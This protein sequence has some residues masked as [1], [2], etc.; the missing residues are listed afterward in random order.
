MKLADLSEAEAAAFLGVAHSTLAHARSDQAALPEEQRDPN[1]IGSIPIISGPPVKYRLYELVKFKLAQEPFSGVIR[2]RSEEAKKKT[3]AT[4]KTNV[5]EHVKRSQN[6]EEKHKDLRAAFANLTHRGFSAFMQ[7]ATGADTWP[8]SIQPDGRPLDLYSA[9]LD[10]KLSGDAERLNLHE[11]A[12]RLVLA[13]SLAHSDSEVDAL[14][15]VALQ[16]EKPVD[17]PTPRPPRK[18]GK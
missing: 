16:P 9:I 17:D 7:S 1:C 18:T 13:A 3:A 12:G 14:E 11:F 5:G 10:G 4:K 8:F 15:A 2:N 6:R